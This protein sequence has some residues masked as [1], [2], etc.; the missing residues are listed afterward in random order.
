MLVPYNGTELCCN[1]YSTHLQ[2]RI[3]L[4]TRWG[5]RTQGKENKA[6]SFFGEDGVPCCFLDWIDQP[7]GS[8]PSRVRTKRYG[9]SYGPWI[10]PLRY[11]MTS[12]PL[13]STSVC[14]RQ[15]KDRLSLSYGR[16]PLGLFET[17]SF[18]SFGNVQSY[19]SAIFQAATSLLEEYQR[20]SQILPH[21]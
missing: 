19:P 18:S 10:F 13:E 7:M 17:M 20:L 1:L 12:S 2:E 8:T 6:C 11:T 3:S 9:G 21:R 5:T 14:V 4:A 16:W 15:M